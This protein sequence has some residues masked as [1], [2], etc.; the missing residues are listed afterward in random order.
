[1]YSPNSNTWW[2]RATGAMVFPSDILHYFFFK[3]L[4]DTGNGQY[5]RWKQMLYISLVSYFPLL[6]WDSHQ[7]FEQ[8]SIEFPGIVRRVP[9]VHLYNVVVF[10]TWLKNWKTLQFEVEVSETSQRLKFE[11]GSRKSEKCPENVTSWSWKCKRRKA[12]K[13]YCANL[14]DVTAK[15]LV[16]KNCDRNLYTS[17]REKIHCKYFRM[18]SNATKTKYWWRTIKIVLLTS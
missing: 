1:M 18:N 3:R 4:F 2:K 15:P 16:G 13:L 9:G 11:I 7:G 14:Y 6:L 8:I 17:A 5:Y 12:L 10:K